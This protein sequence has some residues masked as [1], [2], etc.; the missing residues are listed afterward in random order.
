MGQKFYNEADISNIASAIRAKNQSQSTYKVSQMSAA[1]GN[2]NTAE[3]ITWPQC[4]AAVR[5]YLEKAAE[6][7]PSDTTY[8]KSVIWDSGCAPWD[9]D[10]SK[11]KA[12][13]T[14]PIAKTID[15]VSFYDN[16]PGV[17]EAFS[18]QNKSGTLTFTDRL[19]WIH[20]TYDLPAGVEYPR[21]TNTRDIGGWS[22][23]TGSDNQPCTVKYGMII[24]GSEPNAADRELMVEKLGIK[25]ELQ[26]LPTREQTADRLMK[27]VWG[28][29]WYGNDTDSSSVF[30]ID[31]SSSVNRYLWKKFL[32]AVFDSTAKG[33]PI[34]VHC[35]IGAD[36]TGTVMIMLEAILGMSES[37]I[38][39][40]YELTNFAY[41]HEPN[42]VRRRNN[43][44]FK[45]FLDQINDTPL[46]SGLSNTLEGHAISFALSL[47]FTAEQIN[48]FR[49]ACIDGNPVQINPTLTTY[50]VSK[51]GSNVTFSNN[52]QSVTQY[53]GYETE[54][55]PDLGY[56]ITGVTVT[57]GG[58]DI[59]GMVFSGDVPA[60][61]GT[62]EINTNG[63]HDVA[64]YETAN[65][66]VS[67][68]VISKSISA[69]GT[70]N[71]SS[72]NA[73]GY[74]QVTVNVPQPSGTK[75]ITANGTHDV[76]QYETAVVNVPVGATDVYSAEVTFA[77]R[78][79]GNIALCT[80]PDDVYAHKDDSD[81][82]VTVTNITP[83]GLAADD[84]YN[85]FATNN[86][87]LPKQSGYT[88][89]G[90]G[91][92]KISSGLQV[93]A[94]Y[95]PPKNTTA[96]VGLGG[97]GKV[98]LNNKVLT[99][100]PAFTSYYLGAGTYRITISW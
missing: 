75:N 23:G 40:D 99:L 47:G 29:D 19:R 43:S 80:L 42:T 56:V 59:T 11:K 13:N 12:P 16:T 34:Y 54:I 26:L 18:T 64:R 4:S 17:A 93:I 78:Q 91:L 28:I 2:I 55:T 86:A 49:N 8:S 33:K 35:G 88:V 65:V 90:A 58:T 72:D 21:G 67:P 50:T 70:Y 20:T 31:N 68:N 77:S 69:N 45:P 71:S 57:M 1:I 32:G 10:N 39:Q 96:D 5:K 36:R 37:D 51:S 61:Q 62:V 76:T 79:N 53:Q 41:N 84:F 74:S 87:N 15:G 94:I 3:H 7:Y 30:A 92:K 95:Y 82:T 9:P 6:T 97:Y 48:A 27:S 38:A 73:D 25:S 44:F 85:F 63:S 89:Y 100:T 24:R 22:C 98:W 60:P 46:A 83:A 14:D 52:A 81:F 66:N